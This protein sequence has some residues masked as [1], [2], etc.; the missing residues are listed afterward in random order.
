[1]TGLQLLSGRPNGRGRQLRRARSRRPL[2]HPGPG[3]SVFAR[4]E[5]QLGHSTARAPTKGLRLRS[6]ASPSTSPTATST[7]ATGSGA[8]SGTTRRPSRGDLRSTRRDYT[9]NRDRSPAMRLLPIAADSAGFVYAAAHADGP[10]RAS[11]A[12]DF[13]TRRGF[14]LAQRPDVD[15]AARPSRSIRSPTTSMSTRATGSTSSTRRRSGRDDRVGKLTCGFLRLARG[16]GQRGPP[17][18]STPRADRQSSKIRLRPAA[19]HP[20]DNPA[21]RHATAAAGAHSYGDFQVTPDGRYAAFATHAAADPGYDN[22]GHRGLPLRRAKAG[23][24]R[25]RLVQPD[26]AVASSDSEL[27]PNGLGLLEDGRVFFNT[28]EQLVLSDTNG[29]L[30]AYEWSEGGGTGAAAL[31]STGTS[32]VRLGPARGHR[33]R[34]RRLLLHP[35]HPGRRDHNGQAMKIYDA[36]EGGGIFVIPPPPPCAASDECHGPG[37]G[38]AAAADRHLQGDRRQRE[39]AAEAVQEGLRQEARQVREEAAQEAPGEHGRRKRGREVDDARQRLTATAARRGWSL[40]LLAP[41]PAQAAIKIESFDD[42]ELRLPGRRPSRPDDLVHARRTRR[43]RGGQNVVFNAPEGIFGNPNA[44]TR[45]TV[46]R[47]RPRAVPGR[48]AGRPGHGPRQLQRRPELPARHR[49][50]LRHGAPGGETARFSLHRPDSRHPDR[51]PGRGADRR[52]LRPALHRH[53]NLPS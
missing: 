13:G 26:R 45:C 5:K 30:D 29:K 43:H 9:V 17:T 44:L 6:A 34:H 47:L 31:I 32:L 21:I 36:R 11:T 18:M 14:H 3:V 52:R 41:A 46:G 50:A 25:L 33:R 4:A 38:R 51:D 22:A 53:G 10:S 39:A 8:S 27:P 48:L 15:G 42:D 7:S 1:M 35:R 20:I 12:P 28:G 49:A 40:A 16:R 23:D 37:T 2:R 19:L 24:A